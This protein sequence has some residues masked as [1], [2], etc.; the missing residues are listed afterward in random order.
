MS[1]TISA[2]HIQD[3]ESLRNKTST[4]DRDTDTR[5]QKMKKVD[6]GVFAIIS[7]LRSDLDLGIQRRSDLVLSLDF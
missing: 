1:I 7:Q 6:L 3:Q 5:I 4:L 2:I